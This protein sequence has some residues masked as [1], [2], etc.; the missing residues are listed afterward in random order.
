MTWPGANPRPSYHMKC[1]RA[2]DYAVFC[3]NE[4][5]QIKLHIVNCLGERLIHKT[6]TTRII[7]IHGTII[8]NET[9]QRSM[10]SPTFILR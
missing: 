8:S 9:A 6:L 4:L 3:F 10:D 1:E 7:K 2:N 5:D